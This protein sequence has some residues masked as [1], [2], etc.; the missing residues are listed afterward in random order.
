LFIRAVFFVVTMKILVLALVKIAASLDLS[1]R[2]LPVLEL[3][4]F[5]NSPELQELS[6]DEL[7]SEIKHRISIC[8][9]REEGAIQKVST[10]ELLSEFK[11]REEAKEC[12][13]VVPAPAPGVLAPPATATGDSPAGAPAPAIVTTT[14]TTGP[15]NFADEVV[16]QANVKFDML[17]KNK[18]GC[19]SPSEMSQTIKHQVKVAKSKNYYW[20]MHNITKGNKTIVNTLHLRVDASDADGD[21]CLSKAEFAELRHAI[22]DCSKQFLMMDHSGDGKISRQEAATFVSDHMVHADLSYEKLRD[23]FQ[24]A[25]VNGDNYLSEPEFCEAGPRFE[26]DGDDK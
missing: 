14:T 6:E 1:G 10:E 2:Q 3:R 15:D 25:D 8:G 16:D 18:D 24:T 7:L 11:R 20:Q 4:S 19:I 17:D 12:P 13:S 23:I 21:G 26:G 5:G 9:E 22:G